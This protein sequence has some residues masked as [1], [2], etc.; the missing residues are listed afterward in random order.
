MSNFQT[1]HQN[2]PIWKFIVW[3]EIG[4]QNAAYL[5]LCDLFRALMVGGV[6]Y[7]SRPKKGQ[8]GIGLA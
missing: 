8:V 5:A 7:D 6:K 3:I 1:R 2:I 4:Y